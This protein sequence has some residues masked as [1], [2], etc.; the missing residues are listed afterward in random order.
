MT[1]GLKLTLVRVDELEAHEMAARRWTV[2]ERLEEEHDILG[3]GIPTVADIGR[4]WA[5]WGVPVKHKPYDP[6]QT[7]M[8]RRGMLGLARA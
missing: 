5:Q 1:N 8:T 7:P 4:A 6:G 3:R 2:M